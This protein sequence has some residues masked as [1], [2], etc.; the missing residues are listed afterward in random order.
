MTQPW[1][2]NNPHTLCLYTL[3]SPGLYDPHTLRLPWA[4]LDYMTPTLYVYSGLVHG[5]KLN[6]FQV[7]QSPEQ[8]LKSKKRENSF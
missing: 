5:E 4:H 1:F 7:P 8:D 6:S 2:K 3:G